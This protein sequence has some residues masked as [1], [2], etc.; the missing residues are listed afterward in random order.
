MRIGLRVVGIFHIDS[1]INIHLSQA[2]GDAN[3][4]E[5]RDQDPGLHP[6]GEGPCYIL[7][8]A[9]FSI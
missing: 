7:R 5:A 8:R 6:F 3:G 1:Q 9:T 4:Q 2:N